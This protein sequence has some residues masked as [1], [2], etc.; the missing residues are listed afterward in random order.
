MAWSGD[1][2]LALP[3]DFPTHPSIGPVAELPIVNAVVSPDGFTK[4]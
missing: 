3:L 2:Q 1:T 4:S